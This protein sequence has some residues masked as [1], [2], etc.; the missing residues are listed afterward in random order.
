MRYLLLLPLTI[1]LAM[2]AGRFDRDCMAGIVEDAYFT[3]FTY[4]D[5]VGM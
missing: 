3:T 5:S 1:L 4:V 2:S